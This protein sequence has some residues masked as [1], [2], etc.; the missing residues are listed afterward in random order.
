MP[1][2]AADEG[3]GQWAVERVGEGREAGVPG[4]QDAEADL[5]DGLVGA[6][7]LPGDALLDGG[8]LW[9]GEGGVHHE[10]HLQRDEGA[11]LQ[12][13]GATGR[14]GIGLNGLPGGVRI[15]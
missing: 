11:H 6:E 2:S 9:D 1:Q 14:E 4:R 8:D 10:V 15:P 12:R 3:R 13:R 7:D 5:C